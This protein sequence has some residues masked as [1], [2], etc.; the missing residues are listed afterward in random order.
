[1]KTKAF[2]KSYGPRCVLDVPELE[3]VPGQICAVIGP[4]GSG[5]STLAKILAGVISAD[6]GVKPF[7]GTPD[8]A[9]MPQKSFGFR[10]SAEKNLRLCGADERQ[11]GEMLETLGLSH[12]AKKSA[13]SLSGGE[14]A[15]LSLGRVLLQKQELLILDEPCAS[16]DIESTLL[17]E[18]LIRRYVQKHQAAVLLVTHSLAQ[19]R[20]LGSEALFF[21]NGQLMEAGKAEVVL[22]NPQNEETKRFLEF[23]GE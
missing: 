20:R 16:M 12:L 21:K 17:A 10:M 7:A 6:G 2:Q 15:R 22:R 4:N 9:Y 3:L 14:L 13:K 18:E 23:Y 5:K 19:A 1:M 8:V 11:A